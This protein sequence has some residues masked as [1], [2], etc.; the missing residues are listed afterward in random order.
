[1]AK[2]NFSAV[3]RGRATWKD[4][5]GVLV[6]DGENALDDWL[7]NI[8]VRNIENVNR[9]LRSASTQNSRRERTI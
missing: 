6:K 5:V 4:G 3:L 1:V 9:H 7:A 2:A 8:G